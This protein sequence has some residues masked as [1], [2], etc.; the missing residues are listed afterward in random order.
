MFHQIGAQML[1]KAGMTTCNDEH[2]DLFN[3]LDQILIIYLFNYLGLITRSTNV[4]R[5]GYSPNKTKKCVGRPDG[6][7]FSR[8]FSYCWTRSNIV[9]TK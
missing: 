5:R 2:V 6:V 8:I 1:N 4:R 9:F 7:F 3:Y